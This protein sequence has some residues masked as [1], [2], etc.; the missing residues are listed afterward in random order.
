M[1]G[2]FKAYFT[3]LYNMSAYNR[4]AADEAWKQLNRYVGQLV[5]IAVV[6]GRK[7]EITS[8][9]LREVKD[10]SLVVGAIGYPRPDTRYGDVYVAKVRAMQTVFE[11]E[12]QS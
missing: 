5:E 12:N 9:V 3:V 8:G 7:V 1:L 11:Y 2:L 10:T 4:I 6:S